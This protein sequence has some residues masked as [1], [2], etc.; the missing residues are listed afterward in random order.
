MNEKTQVL[1]S[2][3]IVIGTLL[4]EPQAISKT[5]LELS[6]D[7]FVGGNS[8]NYTLFSAI[9]QLSV[10]GRAVD[11]TSVVQAVRLAGGEEVRAVEFLTAAMDSVTKLEAVETHVEIV[12]EASRKR[13]S[14]VI[15]E[16]ALKRANDWSLSAEEL[17]TSVNQQSFDLV[18]D[19]RKQSHHIWTGG[20]EEQGLYASRMR[21]LKAKETVDPLYSGWEEVDRVLPTGFARS[22]VSV[23]AARP[24]MGKSSWR[25][26]LQRQ[27]LDRGFG[28][29]LISTEQS[30]ETE[31]DRQDSLMTNIPLHEVI[32]SNTWKPGDKRLAMV[33]EANR[34]MDEN[35]NY[36][37][38]FGRQLDMA[39]VWEFMAMVTRQ[40][41]KHWVMID[42]FD[43]LTDVNVSA[44]KP[45]TVSRKLGE[46]SA[47]AEFFNVHVCLIVQI[48]RA[49]ERR[50]NKHPMLSDLKDSGNYE[51]AARLVMLL[52]RDSYYN[53]ESLDNT[54]EVNIAK[55]NQGEAG[56]NIVIPFDFEPM[57]LRYTP[58]ALRGV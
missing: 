25:F 17:W 53:P 47:M 1:E 10:G 49:V 45:Q 11:I 14:I 31:T 58:R 56:P 23:C 15:L 27:F 26:N 5:L 6:H 54:M 35:W 55:Q 4:I 20:G 13:Q 34:Y 39:K 57:T 22:D 7:D 16:D 30:K 9:E 29:V 3:A 32:Q 50:A 44:N 38:F 43:R 37:L 42:L 18:R 2:E 46:A 41:E 33:Q 28:G 19:V 8:L 21:I 24:G 12:K 48:S 40:R 51:E 36:D 52:Y